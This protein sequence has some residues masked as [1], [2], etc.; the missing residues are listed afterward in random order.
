MAL[1]YG[2]VGAFGT[3][4]ASALLAASGY[5]PT[6][7]GNNDIAVG[8]GTA[9]AT[10]YAPSVA[11]SGAQGFGP[12]LLFG[13]NIGYAQSGQI[14]IPPGAG[15]FA[16]YAPTAAGTENTIYLLGGDDLLSEAATMSGSGAKIIPGSPFI[17]VAKG[18]GSFSG[19]TPTALYSILPGKGTGTFTGYQPG[20]L[21][22][23]IEFIG[24][25][26]GTFTGYAPTFKETRDVPAGS[27][28]FAG[29]VPVLNL[30]LKPGAGSGSFSGYGLNKHF[31]PSPEI[32]I[33]PATGTISGGGANPTLNYSAVIPAGAGA[34]TGYIPAETRVYSPPAGSGIFAADFFTFGETRPVGAGAGAFAGKVPALVSTGQF[35]EGA[36]DPVARRATVSGTLANVR[37]ANP[38]VSSQ[39]ATVAGSAINVWLGSGAMQ[40]AIAT[41]GSV[42][43]ASGTGQ[44]N[45]LPATVWGGAL[46]REFL[47]INQLD[48]G[49]RVGRVQ[50]E[51]DAA[52]EMDIKLTSKDANL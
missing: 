1:L 46:L 9:T 3:A 52:M 8:K 41:L 11:I 50:I 35:W 48:I 49:L 29:S 19:K 38:G 36:G 7:G 33:Q 28:S 4:I 23:F 27:G 40:A 16:G 20:Q 37:H 24:A 39:R 13:L 22:A 15:A 51:T 18:T 32:Q 30:A 2:N 25:G 10:G 42:Q 6:L 47:V 44:A 31:D 14:F 43:A 17:A 12:G 26:S 21:T 34:F 45:A 5:A